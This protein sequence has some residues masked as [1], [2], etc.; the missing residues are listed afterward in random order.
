[1]PALEPVWRVAFTVQAN[2][3]LSAVW[4]SA[5]DDVFIVG[6]TTEQAWIYHFD[7]IE[8]SQMAAPAVPQLIWVF[9][10]GTDNVY[11]VGLDGAVIQYDGLQWHIL[12]SGT[13]EDLWGI[14]GT[15]PDDLWLVGGELT[16][17]D[18]VILHYDGQVFAK[19]A[20]PENDRNATSLFKVWGIGDEVFAVG[21]TGLI[22]AFDG[23]RWAQ[24]PAG[25][26][27]NDDFVSLWGTRED[28][29]AAVGGRASG[30]LSDFDGQAWS[31]RPV[32]PVPGLSAVYM[33]QD[34]EAIVGGQR[35]FVGHYN[36]ETMELIEEAAP[37][38]NLQFIHGVWGDD[39]GRHYAVG[40]RYIGVNTTTGFAL[41]RTLE[42][43][44]ERVR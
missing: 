26:A 17:G 19:W 41:V 11:A 24:V 33:G 42:P 44:P 35:G 2:G 14:W 25:P 1:M 30:I 13:D 21:S 3:G 29:I 34:D 36:P 8:W 37:T 22:I 9:G 38:D 20:A 12:D 28:H 40:T 4:G 32:A 6:G 10:F 15:A 18:P 39:A 31:T 27:A 5:P 16:P 23:E 7:G 43:P